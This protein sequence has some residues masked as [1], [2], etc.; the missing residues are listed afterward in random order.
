MKN[1][2]HRIQEIIRE[3]C[4]AYGAS[5][6]TGEDFGCIHYLKKKKIK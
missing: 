6:T 5:F 1:L 3:D 2:Q 4:E